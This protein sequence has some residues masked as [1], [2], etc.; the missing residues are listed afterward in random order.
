M[1]NIKKI[2]TKNTILLILFTLTLI[3]YINYDIKIFKNLN[4]TFQNMNENENENETT[5]TNN[6][7]LDNRKENLMH[8]LDT[9]KKIEIP[10]IIDDNGVVCNDWS[11]D[12]ENRFP[13]KGNKCQL[14][15]SKAYCI[16][17]NNE[18]TTC[19]KLYDKKIQEIAT[20]DIDNLIEPYYNE[21][22][23]QFSKLNND[24]EDKENELNDIIN[25]IIAKKNLN[26]QQEFFIK[27]NSNFINESQN[28]EKDINNEYD[29][30]T[31][32]YNMFKTTFNDTQDEITILNNY[33]DMLKKITIGITIIL[34]LLLIFYALTF[35]IQ[36]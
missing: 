15:K 26:H 24:I 30:K 35:R 20:I 32:D 31:N 17:N 36:D 12:S 7:L 2:L 11:N 6:Y 33:N 22:F 25:R 13:N 1:L 5:K 14:I 4:E 27:Q 29:E 3:I 18:I 16:N 9:V 10:I 34:V 21:L 19:N 8:F 28:V 23:I